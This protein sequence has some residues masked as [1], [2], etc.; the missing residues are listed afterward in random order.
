MSEFHADLP[1]PSLTAIAAVA[2]NGV[3]G[4]GTG[5]PWHLPEDFA[6]FKSV[7]MGGVLV[8]GR[9]TYES[10]GAA[11]RGRTSIVLTRNPDWTPSDTRGCEVLTA[12]DM[13][14]LARLL[15]AR[16]DQR[17][18]SAGGGE[19]YR[20]LWGYTTLLDL[21]EVKM[22]PEGATR[23][24]TVDDETWVETSRDPREQFD[25]VTYA[26]VT[27]SAADALGALIADA[28]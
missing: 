11:L 15:A 8:M 23:F 10:L 1:Y 16:P 9:R 19:I 3:I 20:A 7:T 26:R 2:A 14:G 24:P 27:T 17:W 12:S 6:R 18:W 21:T 25:F 28:R 5:M 22:T 4:D 13:P